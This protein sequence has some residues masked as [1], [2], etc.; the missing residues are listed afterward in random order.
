MSNKYDQNELRQKSFEEKKKKY[1][2][3]EFKD[4]W[5]SNSEK[6]AEIIEGY[7]IMEEGIQKLQNQFKRLMTKN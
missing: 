5:A 1:P 7:K 6:I 4:E 2:R 3:I